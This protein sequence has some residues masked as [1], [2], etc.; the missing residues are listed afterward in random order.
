[1][2]PTSVQALEAVVKQVEPILI[3]LDTFSAVMTGGDVSLDRDQM[4][5][6]AAMNRLRRVC[7]STVLANHHSGW[8]NQDREKGSN[9]LRQAADAVYRLT[10]E[11][12]VRTLT[13]PKVRDGAK[14]DSLRLRLTPAG[15]SC[16]V[17]LAPE[18]LARGTGGLT[19][20]EQ[21]AVDTLDAMGGTAKA[22]AWQRQ[23]KAMFDLNPSSFWEVRK[24]L[25]ASGLVTQGDS[26]YSLTDEGRQ[27]VTPT[28]TP[29]QKHSNGVGPN[30]STP[31][32]PPIGGGVGGVDPELGLENQKEAA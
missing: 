22:M 15:P 3:V 1:M 10:E 30:Y 14:L 7:G 5:A 16:V 4:V 18:G 19:A 17:E 29:L 32:H 21:Q 25:A 20:N 2:D 12:G 6:V 8:G 27:H 26:G 28:P 31:L 9:H 24:R 13:A 11:D 23:A